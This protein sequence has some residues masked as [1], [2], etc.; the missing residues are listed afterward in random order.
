M[1]IIAGRHKGRR[2][3]APAGRELRP[4]TDRTR[5]ALF[6]ILAHGGW[7]PD[8]GNPVIGAV[9][10]DAFCG[11]G[12]L[13]LEALSRGAAEAW[14][15]DVSTGSLAAARRNVDALGES[16][17]THL[18]RTDSTRPPPARARATLVFIAPPYGRDLAPPAI[19][20]LAEQ[21]WMAPDAIVVI[22]LAGSDPFTPPDGFE[23]LDDRGYGGARLLFLRAVQPA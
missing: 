17:R 6:N 14:L 9:V 23:P 22:E 21:G 20:A 18:L 7:G 5:E 1:R 2:L 3:T 10:L 12:A 19:A 13:A 16:D 4:M 11:T 8:R 15:L